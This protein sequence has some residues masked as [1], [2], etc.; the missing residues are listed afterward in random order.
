[1]SDEKHLAVP[2]STKREADLLAENE[3]LK[4]ED[5]ANAQL[6][7][8][9]SQDIAA[10]REQLAAVERERDAERERTNE[11]AHRLR[12]LNADTA[13]AYSK[14]RAARLAAES[15]VTKLRAQVRKLRLIAAECVSEQTNWD[16]EPERAVTNAYDVYQLCQEA[17]GEPLHGEPID[18]PKGKICVKCGGIDGNPKCKYCCYRLTRCT[19]DPTSLAAFTCLSVDCPQHARA[20]LDRPV[21]S[22]GDTVEPWVAEAREAFEKRS[23][24][25]ELDWPL[26]RDGYLRGLSTNNVVARPPAPQPATGGERWCKERDYMNR[27]CVERAGHD[28]DHRNGFLSWSLLP[29]TASAPAPPSAGAG[30]ERWT[31]PSFVDWELSQVRWR[32]ALELLAY[33]ECECD[34]YHGYTCSRCVFLREVQ[35]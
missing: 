27:D 7:K 15:E 11:E 25:T 22:A 1:M 4:R 9:L 13:L 34:D 12:L 17:L 24:M 29:K 21:G 19:C 5:V 10:L 28:G 3:R 35:R 2:P 8:R 20:A 23:E 26:Y 31:P 14:E 6:V 16:E 33:L 32:R 18:R 30:N